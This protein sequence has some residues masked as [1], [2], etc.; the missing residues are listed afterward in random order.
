MHDICKA[1]GQRPSQILY[2]RLK[3]TL[4]SLA[5][6]NAVFE[7]GYR[8][9]LDIQ[10]ERDKLNIKSETEHISMFARIIGRMVR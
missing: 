3:N 2:P 5:I 6:D 1:Y 7:L 10:M 9:E 8:K 4:F